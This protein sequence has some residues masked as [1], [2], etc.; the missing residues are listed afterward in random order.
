M[1][2]DLSRFCCLNEGCSEY[3]NRGAGNLTVC[4]RYGKDKR[5]RMRDTKAPRGFER[6]GYCTSEATR[7]AP[8]TFCRR[9]VAGSAP[10]SSLHPLNWSPQ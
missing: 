3:G 4:A 6:R 7:Q 5:R 8:W 1:S 10:G 9:S 2:E